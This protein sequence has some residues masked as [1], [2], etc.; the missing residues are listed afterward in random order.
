MLGWVAIVV[1]WASLI[2]LALVLVSAAKR[3]EGEFEDFDDLALHEMRRVALGR[4]TRRA[5]NFDP[6]AGSHPAARANSSAGLNAG[7]A[8]WN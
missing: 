5:R 8:R 7:A 1:L 6:A 4:C 3:F 2:G